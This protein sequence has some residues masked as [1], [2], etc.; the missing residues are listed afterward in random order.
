MRC[1]G[2]ARTVGKYPNV[3]TLKRLVLPQAPSP[4]MTNFLP[5]YHD[6]LLGLRTS[7]MGRMRIASAKELQVS[8]SCWPEFSRFLPTVARSEWSPTLDVQRSCNLSRNPLSPR[9][10][11][12]SHNILCLLLRHCDQ[13]KRLRGSKADIRCSGETPGWWV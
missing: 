13:R 11:I 9:H 12:P 3:K 5:W 7:T 1:L 6:Q 10:H 4:M 2:D 8:D